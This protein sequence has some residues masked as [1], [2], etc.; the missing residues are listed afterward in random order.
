M[1]SD[2]S[3]NIYVCK[4]KCLVCTEYLGFVF[5]SFKISNFLSYH[6]I[7][8][9]IL[10]LSTA[11]IQ[12]DAKQAVTIKFFSPL[13]PLAKLFAFRVADACELENI[14]NLAKCARKRVRWQRNSRAEL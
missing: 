8:S 14:C 5:L 10:D 2:F 12:V 4:C 13:W 3:V 6:H 7:I 11:T 9:T 1:P